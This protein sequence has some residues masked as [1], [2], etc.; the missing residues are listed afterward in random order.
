MLP[1]VQTERTDM[2]YYADIRGGRNVSR[3]A[4]GGFANPHAFLGLIFSRVHTFNKDAAIP[5]RIAVYPL[6]VSGIPGAYQSDVAMRVFGSESSLAG[7]MEDAVLLSAERSNVISPGRTRKVSISGRY[8]AWVRTRNED[9]QTIAYHERR[10]E[11]ETA[12]FISRDDVSGKRP[13][14][15][16]ER[17]RDIRISERNNSFVTLSSS[18]TGKNFA[19]R[20]CPVECSESP[21]TGNIGTYGLSVKSS[22]YPLPVMDF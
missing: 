15:L 8:V 19:L 22:P 14:S 9:R 16:S 1:A 13:A 17:I 12:R 7:F 3:P 4:E 5:D 20:F 11:R 2:N 21:Q 10:M 18:G 6:G